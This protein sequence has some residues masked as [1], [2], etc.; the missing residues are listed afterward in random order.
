MTTTK[1]TANTAEEFDS[2][3]AAEAVKDVAKKIRDVSRAVSN[4]VSTFTESGAIT[5]MAEAS[6]DAAVAARDTTRNVASAAEEIQKSGVIN[7]TAKAMDETVSEA[8]KAASVAKKAPGQFKRSTPKTT[9][10]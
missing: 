1:D 8:A 10:A 5:E 2:E 4:T 9:T 3:K 6:R 7:E